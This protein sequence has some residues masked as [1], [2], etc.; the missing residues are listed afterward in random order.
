[1]AKFLSFCQ[2][3]LAPPWWVTALCC[4]SF[5]ALGWLFL[6]GSGDRWFQYPIYVLAFY[7]LVLLC[8]QVI[9]RLVALWK[10]RR[11]RKIPI[12]ERSLALTARIRRTMWINL[13]YGAFQMVLGFW[14][15]SSWTGSNGVYYLAHGLI[16]LV[17]IRYARDYRENIA[18]RG[19]TLCGFLLLGLNVTM[20]GMA[21]QMIWQGKGKHYPGFLVFAV[22]TYTFY[23][24]TMAIIRLIQCRKD[25]SP[26]LGAVRNMEHTGAIMSL[27][28]L[29]TAM[30]SAFGQDPDQEQLM[31]L[32]TGVG[33]CLLTVLG[34]V[35]MILHGR[36]QRKRM[37]ITNGE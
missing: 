11:E 19:Y 8:V 31:N 25:N 27:F 26:I 20:S 29:Q 28:F 17:L 16:Y 35:G 32:L 36:K 18:W 24:L 2:K 30:F 12:T 1:M 23:K 33:V 3:F 13:A 10:R 37:E 22:A 15:Q 34:A 6:S 5:P 7:A 14:Q 9:P 4:L 21:F